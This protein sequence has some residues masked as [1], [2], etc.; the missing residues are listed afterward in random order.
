M[1]NKVLWSFERFMLQQNLS[2]QAFNNS[3]LMP[4]HVLILIYA[5]MRK[6]KY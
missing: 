4:R 5:Q 3:E 2:I 1:G 6:L